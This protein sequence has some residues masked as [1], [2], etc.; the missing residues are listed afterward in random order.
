M[1]EENMSELEIKIKEKDEKLSN[2]SQE[3]NYLTNEI[4]PKLKKEN[5]ELKSVKKE[6]SEALKNST[7][8]YYD[9]LDI[10]ADLSDKLTKVGAEHAVNKV[11]IEKFEDEIA[12]VKKNANSKV[13]EYKIKLENS[14]PESIDQLRQENN[15]LKV[16]LDEK[17]AEITDME[18]TLPKLQAEIDGLRKN[19][20]E[21]GNYKEKV[22]SETKAEINNYK[23]EIAR[24][25]SDL[26]SKQSNYDKLYNESQRTIGDLKNQVN[27]LKKAIDDHSNRGILDRLSNKPIKYDE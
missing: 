27:K 22:N 2:Q 13:E 3:L 4:I 15:N 9:Q 20:I 12:E 18:E 8:K 23:Q 14:N 24:L 21:I 1:T 25:N 7:Q 16:Q 11:R 10:N 19:L 5:S 6:L 17:L 26:K